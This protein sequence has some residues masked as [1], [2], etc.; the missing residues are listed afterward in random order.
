MTNP[1]EYAAVLGGNNPSPT[2]AQGATVLG[3]TSRYKNAVHKQFCSDMIKASIPITHYE[4]RFFWSG[5]SARV[6]DI[7]D[8]LSHTKVKCLWEEM[9]RGWVVYPR[10]YSEQAI[11]DMGQQLHGGE[12]FPIYSRRDCVSV[13]YMRA[14]DAFVEMIK[15][16]TI[17]ELIEL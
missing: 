2:E 16:E 5:P 4:G 17:S 8:V 10:A 6:P 1:L 9:G 14:Q 15:S 3:V 11:E 12:I 13:E 7:Q